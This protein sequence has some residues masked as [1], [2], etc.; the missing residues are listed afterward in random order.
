MKVLSP[1]SIHLAKPGLVSLCFDPSLTLVLS[2]GVL[3]TFCLCVCVCASEYLKTFLM[4]SVVTLINFFFNINP[5][6]T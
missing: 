4:G 2:F 3:A 1:N 6:L 5:T